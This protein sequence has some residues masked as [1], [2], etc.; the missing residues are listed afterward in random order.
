MQTMLRLCSTDERP[1]GS[2]SCSNEPGS[3]TRRSGNL[4][5]QPARLLQITQTS[6]LFPPGTTAASARMRP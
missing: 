3:S 4:Q 2:M 1:P 5:P 6:E